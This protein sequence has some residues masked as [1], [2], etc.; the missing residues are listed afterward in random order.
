MGCRVVI[1]LKLSC[2]CSFE[3]QVENDTERI[4]FTLV[5]IAVFA[6]ELTFLYALA[7]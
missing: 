1:L 4:H 2:S 3:H 7:F 5:L 6:E